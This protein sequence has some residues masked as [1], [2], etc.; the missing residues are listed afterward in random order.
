MS[1]IA[2]IKQESEILMT[3]GFM[4]PHVKNPNQLM[5]IAL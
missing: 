1:D 3:S 5:A 4:P 2:V